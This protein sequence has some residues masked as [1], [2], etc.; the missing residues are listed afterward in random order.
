MVEHPTNHLGRNLRRIANDSAELPGIRLI[1][2]P[3]YRRMFRRNRSGNAYLGIYP[4][5]QQALAHAPGVLPSTYDNAASG[6]LYHDRLDRVRMSD[7]PLL[8]WLSRLLA[9]GQRQ[10]FDLG[11]HI[12]ISYYGFR[13]YLDYPADMR[14]LVHDMPSVMDAGRRWANSHDPSGQ[15]SF[16]G[17]RDDADGCDVL[18]SSGALQYLDYSLAELLERLRNPPPHVLVNL[19]P[20]HPE[21]SYFTLQNLGTAICPY[22]VTA[23][24]RFI[25]DMQALGYCAID[26]WESFERQLRLP[27]EPGYSIDR[28][29]GFYFRHESAAA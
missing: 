9:A 1:A 25:A 8:Y 23:V 28:Y 10:L 26:R 18:M 17:T 7:Y 13:R 29:Y 27:F 16:R 12:G 15:L 3:L 11:G 22:R 21:R 4:T 20:M 14:W 2:K 6:G 5:Y 24:P 19:T